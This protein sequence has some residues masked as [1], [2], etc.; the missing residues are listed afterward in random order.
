[1]LEMMKLTDRKREDTK[2]NQYNSTCKHT[3]LNLD[4]GVDS[5]FEICQLPWMLLNT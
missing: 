2:D 1:M 5:Q 3:N 4:I